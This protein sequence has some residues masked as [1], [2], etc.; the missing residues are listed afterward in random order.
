MTNHLRLGWLLLMCCS[1]SWPSRRSQCG[2]RGF[3]ACFSVPPQVFC[4]RVYAW[5]GRWCH[6]NLSPATSPEFEVFGKRGVICTLILAPYRILW[7]LLFNLNQG[8]L[9]VST[10]VQRTNGPKC[11]VLLGL[12]SRVHMSAVSFYVHY[13]L[14]DSMNLQTGA[15]V[16][17]CLM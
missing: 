16:F 12:G 1:Y 8:R 9:F 6:S 7:L 14:G 3:Y 17:H 13:A 11:F 4:S 2:V 15:G 10:R 5:D